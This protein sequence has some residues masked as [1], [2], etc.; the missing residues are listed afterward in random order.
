MRPS[1]ACCDPDTASAS[2]APGAEAARR[3]ARLPRPLALGLSA[4]TSATIAAWGVAPFVAAGTW[5]APALWAHHATVA[6]GLLVRARHVARRNPGL[7][8]RRRTIGGN[9]KRWD[10]AW[11]AAF[12]PLMAAIAVTAG[13]DHGAH[14][15]ATLPAPAW[16]AGLVLFA[17]AMAVSGRAQA[18]NPFFEGTARIQLDAG[19]RVVDAGPY[20][21]VRHPGYLGLAGWALA[22][23]LLL[24]SVRALVPALGAAAWVLLRTALEDAMLRRELE[25]YAGYA[26]R[27]RWRL[28]PGLW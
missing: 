21:I 24:L 11:V 19:Q 23:P 12:W 2:T 5:R 27:V 20:R 22:S 13:L 14:G 16:L 9:T 6:A 17:G 1:G 18:V 10:L 26:R 4:W 8:A 15:G 25:G 7:R 3:I 28:V